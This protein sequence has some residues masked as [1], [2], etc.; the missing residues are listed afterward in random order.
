MKL[1]I[2]QIKIESIKNEISTCKLPIL[3]T[4]KKH[5]KHNAAFTILNLKIELTILA[6][7]AIYKLRFIY[8]K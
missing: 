4:S 1:D 3:Y 6:W 5:N 7:T 8:I 2:K